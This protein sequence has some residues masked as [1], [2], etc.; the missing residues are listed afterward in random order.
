MNNKK[1]I[2][3]T[4]I[5]VIVLLV[6]SII[7]CIIVYNNNQ[8]IK[9]KNIEVV[10]YQYDKTN[11]NNKT[12]LIEYDRF[13]MNNDTKYDNIIYM[14][15]NNNEYNHVVIKNGVIK[16]IEANCYNHVCE[17]MIIDLNSKDFNLL[18]PDSITIDCKPH[19]LK[20]TLEE[21]K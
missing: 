17:R 11:S 2:L 3:I 7:G 6:A 4:T 13:V 15:N 20:I 8:K 10:I 9:E 19:G 12:E 1:T 5:I 14:L 21:I 18:I 16:V